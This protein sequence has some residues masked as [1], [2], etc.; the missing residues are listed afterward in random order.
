[1]KD[2][3]EMSYDEQRAL[4]GLPDVRGYAG[5]YHL[6]RIADAA[7]TVLSPAFA[8]L[9]RTAERAAR[10]VLAAF[11][12]PPSLPVCPACTL[13]VDE[14]REALTVHDARGRTWHG[15]CDPRYD[16]PCAFCGTVECGSEPCEESL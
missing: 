11:A 5:A 4:L 16:D 12:G 8:E 14:N 3:T 2:W 10:S 9:G 6:T 7:R 1:V 13:P 15:M